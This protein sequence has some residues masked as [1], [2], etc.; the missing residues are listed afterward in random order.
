M[1]TTWTGFS[2]EK[3][4]LVS[5]VERAARLFGEIRLEA[6]P[7]LTRLI[8]R[9]M[10]DGHPEDLVGKA[11]R[12]L[13]TEQMKAIGLDPWP[14]LS[15]ETIEALTETGR[16]DPRGAVRRLVERVAAWAYDEEGSRQRTD[17]DAVRVYDIAVFRCGEAACDCAR[18]LDGAVFPAAG[19]PRVP[20]DECRHDGCWCAVESEMSRRLQKKR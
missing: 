16:S 1:K 12:A 10:D 3:I 11:G 7:R 4:D 5:H 20:L 2:G 17:P 6:V 18:R 8:A 15:R 9:H 19:V 13:T 14:P